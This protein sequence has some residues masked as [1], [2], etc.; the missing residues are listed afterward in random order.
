M[1]NRNVQIVQ[2]LRPGG[3]ETLALNLL[4]HSSHQYDVGII[5]LEGT[6]AE[7]YQHWPQLKEFG[8]QLYF[9][10]KPA[11]LSLQTV[12]Q[13][14]RL[15][16]LLRVTHFHT[17]HLGPLLY[18]RL[19]QIS[20][21][22][23]HIHTEHDAW[24]LEDNKQRWLTKLLLTKSVTVVTDAQKV[25]HQLQQ[26]TGRA[27]DKVI[28]NGIDTHYFSLAE[29]CIARAKLDL[30]QSTLLLGCAGRLVNEKGIDV[31]FHSLTLLPDNVNVVIAG[32]GEQE[33]ALK[34]LAKKLSVSHRIHWLGHCHDM[35]TFYQALDLFCM[36]SR[37]EGLPLAILEAQSCGCKVVATDVGAT[38]E[39][40]CPASG[41]IV[42]K[43]NPQ[44]LAQAIRKNLEHTQHNKQI[45]RSFV[46]SLADIKTMVSE[47]ELLM[48]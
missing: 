34:V 10:N 27:V 11:G 19:A 29:S 9:L 24:H 30:P 20:L 22:I 7:A 48:N 31:L 35:P 6:R 36:P 1:K 37:Q 8:S 47:Y 26:H 13:L 21:D 16:K 12:N 5:A 2:H 41:T 32:Q 33:S 38:A 14:R 45:G 46:R 15:L 39:L 44:K 4:R 23:Q 25:A 42:E 3:I 40:L 43:N 18:G 17:H 28:I